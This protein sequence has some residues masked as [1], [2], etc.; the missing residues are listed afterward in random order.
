MI[1]KGDEKNRVLIW[2]DF[3]IRLDFSSFLFGKWFK[4]ILIRKWGNEKV[5]GKKFLEIYS[6]VK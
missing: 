3:E 2:I 5:K 1:S 4:K 6:I